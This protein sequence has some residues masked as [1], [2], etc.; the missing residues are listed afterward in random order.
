[1][2]GDALGFYALGEIPV[3]VTPS[4]AGFWTQATSRQ[5]FEEDEM[6]VALWRELNNYYG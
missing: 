5:P 3:T 6:L 1:M 2:W 4:F